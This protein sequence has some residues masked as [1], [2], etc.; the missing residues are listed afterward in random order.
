[1]GTSVSTPEYREFTYYS[2]AVLGISDGVFGVYLIFYIIVF[3]QKYVLENF[4][5]VFLFSKNRFKDNNYCPNYANCY[6][7]YSI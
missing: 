6:K 4:D 7:A 5:P 1:M 2:K 3:T